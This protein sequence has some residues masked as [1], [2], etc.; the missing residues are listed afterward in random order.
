M[1]DIILYITLPPNHLSYNYLI[2]FYLF[3]T[4]P[5]CLHRKPIWKQRSSSSMSYFTIFLILFLFGCYTRSSWILKAINHVR[6]KVHKT[7]QKCLEFNVF[8][9]FERILLC[10]FKSEKYIL[11]CIRS[12]MVNTKKK[13]QQNRFLHF[14]SLGC[15]FISVRRIDRWNFDFVQ[16]IYA[17]WILLLKKKTS[18]F[19]FWAFGIIDEK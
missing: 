14:W 3:F 13:T 4:Y 11:Q 17:F 15:S 16:V 7:K 10:L 1:T 5:A 19:L 18:E 8:F 12:T 9:L 6:Q 2:K